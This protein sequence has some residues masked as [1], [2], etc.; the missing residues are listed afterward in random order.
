M[1]VLVL[2]CGSSSIKY[3]LLDVN[4]GTALAKGLLEKIGLPDSFFT[5][6]PLGEEAV[7]FSVEVKD[8]FSGLE[9]VTSAL[10]H[11]E[12]GVVKD[13]EEIDATG[14]RVVHGGERFSNSVLITD[15]VMAVVEE[16][17]ELAPLHNPANIM[18]IRACKRL[19]PDTPQVAVF[20]TAFHQTI[21][22][23]IFL[24][25]LPYEYYTKYKL[26]RYGFHGTSH[27]YVAQKAAEML[28]RPLEEL[29]LITCHLGNG[30]SVTA[31]QNGRSLD[32]S[33]GFTPLEGLVMGTR[34]GDLDPAI[35]LFLME[36]EGLSTQEVNDLFNRKSGFLGLSGLSND[37]RD[38]RAAAAKGHKRAR[39]ALEVYPYRVKKRIGSYT[40]AMGGVDAIVFT[41]GIGENDPQM[42]ADICTGLEFLG[43]DID[44][45]K[46]EATR[47]KA[48]DI[49]AESAK[50]RVLVI[51]T[52]EE[53]M[54]ARE[55]KQVVEASK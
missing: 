28:C 39:I 37:V 9:V 52:N 32:T 41:A 48:G 3:Q 20:D 26:R 5:H 8:H 27:Q 47:G 45:Q 43:V 42:R 53:L 1:L 29:K 23:H 13:L 49:S 40:A 34:T 12:H 50:V 36:K 19:M 31:V 38:L 16:C 7:N 2:N 18:G 54:I 4:N 10:T 17:A 22:R 25:A 21:P 24:Y 30:S 33:M 46:N 11:P 51:P 6:E 14:H 44:P 55:T 35:A 15:E